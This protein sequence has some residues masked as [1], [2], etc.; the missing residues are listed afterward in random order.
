MPF[1]NARVTDCACSNADGGPCYT[2]CFSKPQQITI[3]A[4]GTSAGLAAAQQGQ[5]V[6]YGIQ[7]SELAGRSTC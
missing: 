7:V 1:Q 2:C 5:A 3:A 4:S 6:Y